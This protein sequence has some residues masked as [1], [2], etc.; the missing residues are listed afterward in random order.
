MRRKLPSMHAIVAFEAAASHLNFTRAAEELNVQQP[1]ISRQIQALEEDLGVELFKR[2][3]RKLSLTEEGRQLYRAA[4]TGLDAI[5]TGAEALRQ[6]KGPSQIL[7]GAHAGI[8]QF[9]LNKRLPKFRRQY[10]ETDIR[11]MT[12]DQGD[13][14]DFNAADIYIRFGEG[15][16]PG[17]DVTYLFGEE[18]YPICSPAL[19][20][21]SRPDLSA[22]ELAA[23]PLIHLNDSHYRWI[24]WSVFLREQGHRPSLPLPGITVDTYGLLIQS[25]LN[26]EGIG[27]GWGRL[28]DSYI[29]DGRL[30]RPSGLTLESERGFYCLIKDRLRARPEVVAFVD[31]IKRETFLLD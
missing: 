20:Q 28:V 8:A 12:R 6:T 17:A 2:Q 24:D 29:Q 21:N 31:W 16:W 7:I 23:Q 19:L 10:P 4:I 30:I 3:N 5:E 27:L 25:V 22:G 18:V 1:A 13:H 26:G 14:T 15:S 11:L 9:W